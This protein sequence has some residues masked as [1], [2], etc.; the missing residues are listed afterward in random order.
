[1]CLI[2]V[3]ALDA[4]GERGELLDGLDQMINA[5]AAHFRAQ[6]AGQLT[7]FGGTGE[8][9]GFSGVR[10]AKGKAVISQREKLKWEKELLG[11]YVSDHPL[12]AVI[13]KIGDRITHYSSQLTEELNGQAVTLVGVVT[14]IRPHLTKKGD[15]MAF[16]TAEDLQGSLELVLFPK[17][18]RS[19]QSW[20]AVEQIVA[21]YGKVDAGS[22]NSVK[23]LVDRLEQNFT[24][25]AIAPPCPTP[26]QAV[27]FSDDEVILPAPDD[28]SLP[29]GYV[30][31]PPDDLPYED[32]L[33]VLET[34]PAQAVSAPPPAAVTPAG[35]GSP[36]INGS[37]ANAAPAAPARL[38]GHTSRETAAPSAHTPHAPQPQRVIVTLQASG[39]SE[40]DR[41]LLRAVYRI[42][43]AQRGPDEFE[44]LI[45]ENGHQVQMRFPNCH[46]AFTAEVRRKL[47]ELVGEAAIQVQ[48]GMG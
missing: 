26:A 16:V 1:E 39:D 27:M 29:P 47:A 40:R 20:L 43:T 30:P 15:Q 25:L 31:P 13:D 23:I 10:L 44:F 22:G 19:V 41:K 46:I 9:A 7:L 24:T 4:F 3:G 2:K 11:L 45:R 37:P 6:E 32:D 34:P 28:D 42:L 18:W 36:N 35:N 12:Q 8:A 17:T 14:N 48:G 21:I 33:S 38:G 5:S